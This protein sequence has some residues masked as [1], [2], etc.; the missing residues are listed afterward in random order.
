MAW[1]LEKNYEVVC[2]MCDV[3]Q[4]GTMLET[5][6][7][8]PNVLTWLIEDFE[9]AKEKALKIG[10][11]KCIVDDRRK[12]FVEQLIFP[13]IQANSIYENVYLLGETA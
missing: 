6:V 4:E 9:A 13:S 8:M 2:Y 12:E 7:V 11:T 1:L 10:A 5:Y 3:G